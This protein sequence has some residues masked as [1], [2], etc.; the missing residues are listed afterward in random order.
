MD[1]V[2]PNESSEDDKIILGL[3]K[4]VEEGAT[5]Q[6]R[7]ASDL[8]VALGL[9]NAYLKRCVKKGYVKVRGAP[10]RR[11]AYYLT[12]RGFA[13]KSRLTVEYLSHSFS[14]FRQAKADCVELFAAAKERNFDNLV[15]WGKSDLAEIAILSALES[16]V[17]IVA[18]VDANNAATPFAGKDVLSDLGGLSAGFDAVIVTDV[19][20]AGEV[21]DEAVKLLGP[22]RVLAPKLLGLSA[23]RVGGGPQ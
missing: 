8:G 23:T 2:L 19:R 12:P 16:G 17:S 7:I 20:N 11:Y 22:D 15:L 10:A 5:S 1:R 6:R 3:L 21:F 4:S 18:V 14:F 9:V 13:E